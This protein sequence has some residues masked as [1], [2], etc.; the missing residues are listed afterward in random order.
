M[1]INNKKERFAV[2]AATGESIVITWSTGEPTAAITQT[3][4]D[5]GTPTV[6]ELG[7]YVANIN[8]QYD[9]VLAD[10]ADIRTKLDA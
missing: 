7:Q 6:A 2:S 5:G 3:I 4:A 8:A 1:G 9:K 10:I